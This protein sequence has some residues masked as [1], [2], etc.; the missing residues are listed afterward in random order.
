MYHA[1]QPVLTAKGMQAADSRTIDTFGIPGF[2]LMETAGRKTVDAIIRRYGSP[3]GKKFG[4]LCGSGNNGGDGFVIA[5]VLASCGGEVYVFLTGDEKKLTSDTARNLD[6]LRKLQAGDPTLSVRLTTGPEA[7]D[8]SRFPE[9][10]VWIDAMLGTGLSS[11]LREPYRGLVEFLNGNQKPV[12]SV[13]IAT[14]LSATTGR[15]L[16][17]AVSAEMTVTM[18]AVK[19]G[20]ILESGPDKSGFVHVVEIGIP[21]IFLEDEVERGNGV[22]QPTD[23]WIRSAIPRRSRSAHKYDA[24]Y[25]LV[26]AGSEGLTGAATMAVQAAERAGAG[27]V[28]CAVPASLQSIMASKLISSMPFGLRE[29]PN[30]GIDNSAIEQLEAHRKKSTA[31]LVG[32]GLGRHEST[33]E[34][35]RELIRTTDK[36]TVVDADG[37]F[38][39][40]DHVVEIGELR[41]GNWILTPH[42]GEFNRLVDRDV[43]KEES[44]VSLVREFATKWN[45]ILLLKG[46]P[47]IV[48]TPNGHVF[49]NPT[50]NVAAATAGSG[51]VLAGIIAGFLAQGMTP[52][53]ATVA[54]LYVAGKTL[55]QLVSQKFEN[56]VIA[57]DIVDSLPHTLSILVG[58]RQ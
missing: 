25:L 13:D 48:G 22:W 20:H 23:S 37:L 58:K 26:V 19:S 6:L 4:I 33:V 51:D 44:R 53:K 41:R 34:F 17:N 2:T 55:E 54:G 9:V 12:V 21:G 18:A 56:S 15:I 36:P 8:T 32:C 3:V 11:D 31:L 29:S 39:C 45:A 1:L 7:H 30:G 46:S 14:G 42:W 35:V 5:R 38:A 40:I 16:G 24:G 27:G 52:E 57:T 43:Q 50:G 10:N 47:G 49:V 28:I